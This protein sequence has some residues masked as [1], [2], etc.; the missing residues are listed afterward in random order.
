MQITVRRQIS[1]LPT[2]ALRAISFDV[3]QTRT[4][5]SSRFFHARL[6]AI[7][8]ERANV[9]TLPVSPATLFALITVVVVPIELIGPEQR[10]A[11][12]T[13]SVF[14]VDGHEIGYTR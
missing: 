13:S 8:P 14:L 3:F 9:G 4:S 12:N 7:S 5:S 10:A 11:A 6:Y 1:M 2:P